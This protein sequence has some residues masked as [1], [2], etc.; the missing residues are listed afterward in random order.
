M[1][2]ALLYLSQGTCFPLRRT[3]QAL[4]RTGISAPL[5]D[6]LRHDAVVARPLKRNVGLLA[7]TIGGQS[8]GPGYS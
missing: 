7:L 5:I 2:Q 3:E 4:Q 8:Y 1:G 6:S